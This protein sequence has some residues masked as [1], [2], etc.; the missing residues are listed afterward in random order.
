MDAMSTEIELSRRVSG[1]LAT[2]WPLVPLCAEPGP[3][4]SSVEAAFRARVHFDLALEV[5]R[6]VPAVGWSDPRLARALTA[7]V[8]FGD[9]YAIASLEPAEP[10]LAG[11]LPNRATTRERV[12]ALDIDTWCSLHGHPLPFEGGLEP[13]RVAGPPAHLDDDGE[14]QHLLAS[15]LGTDL[16]ALARNERPDWDGFATASEDAS[17]RLDSWMIGYGT[18]L[19]S[20][21]RVDPDLLE[22]F[23]REKRPIF[24][25]E[26]ADTRRTIFYRAS[27]GAKMEA[28][29]AT[30]CLMLVLRSLYLATTI[31]D[32]EDAAHLH[33]L[34]VAELQS[35]FETMGIATWLAEARRT[36]RQSS[37]MG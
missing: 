37:G 21:D 20:M 27:R 23:R 26:L 15:S 6:A 22:V 16:P 31:S 35:F 1:V 10:D 7:L 8:D 17:H 33:F 4:A 19:D 32:Q 25:R 9:A 30:L 24:V 5:V 3:G 18:L 2:N 29:V 34:P 11:S 14:A 12:C 36:R 28:V 13:R